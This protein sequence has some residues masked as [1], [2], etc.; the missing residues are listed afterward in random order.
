LYI[1][2]GNALRTEVLYGNQSKDYN[3]FITLCKT[4]F[5]D[6]RE[7]CPESDIAKFQFQSGSTTVIILSNKADH[8]ASQHRRLLFFDAIRWKK[9]SPPTPTVTPSPT[10]VPGQTTRVSITQNS[11]DAGIA[12]GTCAFSHPNNEVYFGACA[13]G[14]NI[15]SG[16]R[17]NNIQIPR[18]AVIEDAYIAFSVDGEY[19]APINVNIYGEA[20]SNPPTFSSTNT[21]AQRPITSA[22][23]SW[24]ITDRWLLGEKRNTPNLS[25]LVQEI[26]NR[27]DWNSGNSLAVIFKNAGSGSAHRRVIAI[28]RASWDPNLHPAELVVTYRIGS[29]PTA[30]PGSG[31]PGGA[32]STPQPP[33]PTPT[34]TLPPTATPQP[35]FCS[36]ICPQSSSPAALRILEQETPT[37]IPTPIPS[38]SSSRSFVQ[39]ASDASE[40][41]TLLYRVRDEVMN[42]SAEGQRLTDLFYAYAPNLAQ[43]FIAEP[44]LYDEG[45]LIIK[46]FV[47][48]LQAM[49]DETGDAVLITE[50]QVTNMQAF[51][52]EL[53]ELG[54]PDLQSIIQAELARRPLQSM[55]G[56]TM[57]DAWV[58]LNGYELT[59]LPPVSAANPYM[60]QSGRTIPLAFTVVDS[61]DNFVIDETITLQL[62]DSVG[63]IVIGPV[64]LGTNPTNG[65]VIQGSK[66]HY[67]LRT[68]DLPAGEYT[69]Q[70]FYNAAAQTEPAIWTIR[71]KVK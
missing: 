68:K 64:G 38:D 45:V 40:L 46:S 43:V 11:D 28:E 14:G 39:A 53:A 58:Y 59:W 18:N 32:T 55:I 20:S 42:Q 30:T 56:M 47:P 21:P 6:G 50:N 12:P 48:G 2:E 54:D 49:L 37:P 19:T 27:G 57:N 63:N 36:L 71:V 3:Q 10:M 24:N 23:A 67:N 15:T 22:F 34:A 4:P 51:L 33:T 66:Y 41:A 1:Q 17:F 26:V 61:H 69:L 7:N 44:A 60:V 65:I 8:D 70:V 35:C 13:N 16:F 52:D 9:F 29:T 25:M 62:V 31:T 5:A